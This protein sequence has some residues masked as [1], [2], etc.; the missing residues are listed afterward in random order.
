[1]RTY[2]KAFLFLA[3]TA[4]IACAGANFAQAAEAA[5]A[6]QAQ[7][8]GAAPSGDTW[9]QETPQPKAPKAGTA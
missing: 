5:P 8:A 1:M 2:L 9:G 3:L 4:S 6:A 7:P